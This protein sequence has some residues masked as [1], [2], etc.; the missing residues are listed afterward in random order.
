VAKNVI[1]TTGRLPDDPVKLDVF[2]NVKNIHW[3]DN[4]YLVITARQDE[5]WDPGSNMEWWVWSD[6]FGATS[7]EENMIH[8]FTTG[9][10]GGELFTFPT[11]FGH[12]QTAAQEA[13]NYFQGTS[14]GDNVHLEGRTEV[15]GTPNPLPN[16]SVGGVVEIIAATVPLFIGT[17]FTQTFLT[18]SQEEL[19][20]SYPPSIPPT[21]IP[22]G[23]V[24]KMKEGKFQNWRSDVSFEEHPPHDYIDNSQSVAVFNL[25]EYKAPFSLTIQ[26][27]ASIAPSEETS[28]TMTF[29]LGAFIMR[30][31]KSFTLP[32]GA[33]P[34]SFV[35]S[36]E[37]VTFG[38]KY[39]ALP[40]S[41][42]KTSPVRVSRKVTTGSI[43]LNGTNHFVQKI[44]ILVVDPVKKTIMSFTTPS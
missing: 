40:A 3:P 4:D 32:A 28:G 43:A 36:K 25:K 15:F 18:S 35:F 42:P 13:Y 34:A 41:F 29:A 2:Q 16:N 26:T 44:S 30:G 33:G 21:P 20:T 9:G 7:L 19:G 11:N 31:L 27:N 38:L 10:P 12:D 14:E 8:D 5:T 24:L 22:W 6:S 37:T 17:S 1:V 23:D 39:E